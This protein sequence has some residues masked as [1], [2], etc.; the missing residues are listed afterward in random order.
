M[1]G[2]ARRLVSLIAPVFLALSLLAG[3]AQAAE[4]RLRDRL[5]TS[6]APGNWTWL[7]LRDPSALRALP[8]R[9]VLHVDQV[10]FRRVAV[11][12]TAKDGHVERTV[13]R[14]RELG[15]N[16]APGGLLEFPMR[17][18]GSEVASL[19]VG[20]EDIDSVALLRKVSALTPSQDDAADDG[21]LL[22]MGVFAG[23][24]IS[25]FVYNLL[26]N[27]GR[28]HAFQR[29]YLAWVATALA[30][31]L[32][33]TN[34]AGLGLPWLVGPD[35]V[36]FDCVLVGLMVALGAQFLTAVLEPGKV[37]HPLAW[38]IRLVALA[39]FAAGIIAADE[40]LID[41]RVSD[42]LLNCAMATC[43]GASLVAIV[44]A[45]VRGS[46][47]VWL[48]LVGWAP[49]IAVFAGRSVRNFGLIGQSDAVDMATFA[50]MGF[51]S[52]VFSLIIA[53]RFM[54]LRRERDVA[55]AN[56]RGMEIERETLTRAAHTDFLTGLGNRA[57][58]H[59]R[60]RILHHEEAPLSLFLLDV[61]YLKE[62]NDRQGHDAGDALLQFIGGTLAELVDERTCCARIGGDEFA[63]LYQGPASE[64]ASFI[65]KL[66]EL[67]GMVWARHTW[68]G[69]LSLS[70]GC[71]AAEKSLTPAELFQRADIALY[72]AKKQGRGRMQRFDDRLRQQ[73]ESRHD[74]IRQARQGLADRQFV[75]HFQPIVDVSASSLVGVEA[76]LRWN[77]PMLGQIGPGAFQA[78]LADNELGPA[79]QQLVI[80]LAIDELRRRPNFTGTLAVNFTAMDLNG[81]E[82]AER[83]L[84]K[85]AQVRV[86]PRSLCVEVTEGIIL[87]NRGTAPAEALRVLHEAGVHIALDDF[88][89]GYAS[90]VHLKEI[91]V[92][93]LKIDRSFVAGL[94]DPGDESEEI[95]RAVLALGHGLKKNVVAEGVESVAQLLRLREFGCDQAQGFLFGRPSPAF[96]SSESVRA[97][98]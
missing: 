27:A 64:A 93:T 86:S 92:D 29:W 95:V 97:A 96:P 47:V 11:V 45:A 78:V 51:E 24:L 18:A 89:T 35:A 46:R 44:T 14:A 25:A 16:W 68:S 5:E 66:D 31:G 33:W 38:A 3:P 90:L 91:P 74:L 19:R 55:E 43:V 53:S 65:R 10:R 62:L 63:V 57:F 61:D 82:A 80:Q 73:I 6:H 7:A 58:F 72:E 59:E 13:L 69:M 37:P 98:A 28:R 88:G 85:L 83:L 12:L 50:A 20:F 17:T 52:L 76:L 40:A 67:Q 39:C 49:V 70:I 23:L 8:H 1:F 48:Y 81:R 41:A 84:A 36:R 79:L 15:Q 56:A 77:H 87:G 34:V 42:L 32:T 60:M 22:L 4:V 30:Y 71:A 21:W 75:L 26:V 9:W 54:T 2:G 94:L